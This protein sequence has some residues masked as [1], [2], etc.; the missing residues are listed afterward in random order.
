[1]N[2]TYVTLDIS[3]DKLRE[4]VGQIYVTNYLTFTKKEM[5]P[6]RTRY[7][8]ASYIIIKC[9]DYTVAKMLVENGSTLNV[10]P[11]HIMDQ[12]HID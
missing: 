5:D 10:L 11:C 4:L 8:K 6:M 12:L 9:K 7:T 2:E 1:M 3:T